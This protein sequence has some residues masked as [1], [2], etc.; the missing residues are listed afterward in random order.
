M[1]TPKKF[2]VSMLK[3][4][5]FGCS[6]VAISGFQ[7][8]DADAVRKQLEKEEK[9]AKADYLVG[10]MLCTV[11]LTYQQHVLPV[12]QERGWKP[13]DTYY[14]NRVHD[15]HPIQVWCKHFDRRP[16]DRV[17][18]DTKAGISTLL[19]K[20]YTSPVQYEVDDED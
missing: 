7:W 15:Y 20:E 10:L 4:K 11:V 2:I 13:L 6:V 19:D 3:T 12:L 1:E 14:S 16:G 17:K 8:T 5:P 18:A 9:A